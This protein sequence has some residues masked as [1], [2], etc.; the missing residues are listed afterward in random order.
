MDQ[1]ACVQTVSVVER[2]CRTELRNSPEV[3]WHPEVLGCAS[4]HR[5]VGPSSEK[6][7]A[8]LGGGKGVQ[9]EEGDGSEQPERLERSLAAPENLSTTEQEKSQGLSMYST[10][11]RLNL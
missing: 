6:L 1:L 5:I 9:D 4:S 8:K 3:C 2:C 11:H 10:V 7:V